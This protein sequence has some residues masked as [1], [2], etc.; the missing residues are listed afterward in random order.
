MYTI[1]RLYATETVETKKKNK[2]K[3]YRLFWNVML[4]PVLYI[5]LFIDVE[6][7]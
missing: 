2:I 1:W 4:F 3:K 7:R 5:D 6:I